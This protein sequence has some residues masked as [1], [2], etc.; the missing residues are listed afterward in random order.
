MI[1]R[2]QVGAF[3]SHH[4]GKPYDPDERYAAGTYVPAPRV[5]GLPAWTKANRSME[6]GYRRCIP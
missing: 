2:Q 6:Y 3:S 1:Q 5:R 4:C